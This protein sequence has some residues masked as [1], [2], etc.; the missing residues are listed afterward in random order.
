MTIQTIN[1]GSYANDGT[2]D[3]LRTAFQKVNANFTELSHTVTIANAEN[4]GNGT[5]LF[6]QRA[7][8]NLQFK[9]L[10][11]DDNSVIITHSADWVNLQSVTQVELDTAP[12]LGANLGLNGHNIYGP[13]DVQTTIWG[14]D[15]KLL[16]SLVTTLLYSNTNIHVDLGYIN[17]PTGASSLNPR[18]VSLDFGGFLGNPRNDVEFGFFDATP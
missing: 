1:L 6:A 7:N 2:G 4:I 15:M 16:S 9:S 8:A 5:G 14:E 18:G 11:S 13:G 3:D 12:L 10:L 17:I